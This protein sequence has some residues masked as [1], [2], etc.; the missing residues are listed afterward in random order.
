M[1]LPNNFGGIVYLG[2]RRRRPY[3]ARVTIG[4]DE[5]KKQKYRYLG[6]FATKKEALTCLVE[7]N[8]HPFDLNAKKM[9]LQETW[10]DWSKNHSEKVSRGTMNVY[11]STFNR[12]ERLYKKPMSELRAFHFQSLI[13]EQ[14]YSTAK[15]IKI[16]A[17]LLF[18]HAMKFDAVDKD[19]SDLLELPKKETKKKKATLTSEQIDLIIANEGRKES[20]ML[21]ILLY[22]GLRISELLQMETK[23]IDLKNRIMVGGGKTKAGTDRRIPIHKR[24]IPVIERNIGEKYLFTSPRGGKFH[25]CNEGMVVNGYLKK[26]GIERTCHELRHTF[27]SQCDRIGIDKILIKR[28]VGHSTKD[29]TEHYT[30]KSDEDLI[31][32]IDKFHY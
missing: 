2:K 4:W 11:R 8:K 23:N 30:H 6:Y 27:I 1:R 32:A 20:D 5:N 15:M 17:G 29:I 19:Y 16:I 24:I 26:I 12:M 21:I 7:F 28:I 25:Y 10:D 18:K 9:T 3:G 14:N 22:T 31:K 13:D